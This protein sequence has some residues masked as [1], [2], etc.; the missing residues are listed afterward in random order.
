M[1]NTTTISTV[2]YH[3]VFS[4]IPESDSQL[5]NYCADPNKRKDKPHTPKALS[6]LLFADLRLI[7]TG[8]MFSVNPTAYL[9]GAV[10]GSAKPIYDRVVHQVI[11]KKLATDA[12]VGDFAKLNLEKRAKAYAVA[13]LVPALVAAA[14]QNALP[15]LSSLIV[16]FSGLE[17]ASD[18]TQR[19]IRWLSA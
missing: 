6:D 9:T 17:Y 8:L 19:T 3:V 2:P 11:P 14:S 4:M 10:L 13:F 12:D 15:L 5:P 7:A 16:G 1:S 18:L